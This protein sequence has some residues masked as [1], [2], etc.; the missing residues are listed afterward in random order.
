M[1]VRGSPVTARVPLEPP[2][3]KSYAAALTP[4]VIWPVPHGTS[5]RAAKALQPIAP[6]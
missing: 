1:R 2:L 6:L 4:A 5:I 3:P